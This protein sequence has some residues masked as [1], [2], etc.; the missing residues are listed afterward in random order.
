MWR[1][2]YCFRENSAGSN[3]WVVEHIKRCAPLHA[4]VLDIAVLHH[5]RT[6]PVIICERAATILCH[7]YIFRYLIRA[8]SVLSCS[9][10]P[11]RNFWCS[12]YFTPYNLLISLVRK[13]IVLSTNSLTT[14]SKNTVRLPRSPWRSISC[15]V[16]EKFNISDLK[17]WS[18]L[19]ET[20]CLYIHK[21][22]AKMPRIGFGV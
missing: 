7:A 10:Y 5:S 11:C 6:A 9:G 13:I 19:C 20:P 15:L 16:A 14:R 22:A 18:K 12:A 4:T 17:S 2:F 1:I 3:N 21:P 8:P